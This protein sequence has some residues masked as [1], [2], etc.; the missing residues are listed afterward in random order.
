MRIAIDAREL[1]GRATGVGRCLAGVLGEWQH[2][3]D[4]AAHEFLLYTHG[5]LPDS[6]DRHRFAVR[7]IAGSGGTRWEQRDLP[8]AV[9]QDRAD[10]LFSPAYTT[11]LL[12][13]IPRVVMVHDVSF[14]AH[15]EW[16]HWRE[17]TRRRILSRQSARR[18]RAVITVS[19]FSKE[20]IIKYFGT[21]AERIHV[22]YNGV[23]APPVDP[24]ARRATHEVRQ[25]RRILYAGSIF[26]RR[27]VPD[28]LLGFGLLAQRHP[29]VELDLVGDDRSF[30]PE[31]IA[32]LVASVADPR[33]RWHQYVPDAELA[34][35]YG[36][37]DAFAFLSEYEGFGL[38]PLEAASV[39]IPPL[40][41]DTPV[42][43]EVCGNAALF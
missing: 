39:G 28:L 38:T 40:V 31:D 3:P 27:H 26:N 11:P 10:V 42:A 5:D 25:P 1:T 32:G 15:P 8:R 9:A 7:T 6:L 43:R 18:A 41:L 2:M 13:E 17:G 12:T 4:A 16:F 14:A 35:L 20:E 29:N 21:P 19:E 30:P 24:S 34:R 36:G 23:T 37:A 22:I 33:V